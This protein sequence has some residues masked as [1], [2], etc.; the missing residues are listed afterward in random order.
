MSQ[1]PQVLTNLL[2]DAQKQIHA[3]D[4]SAALALMLKAKILVPT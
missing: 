2:A 1:Q 3:Q 4:W